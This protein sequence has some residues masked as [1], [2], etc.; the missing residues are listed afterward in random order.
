MSEH[1]NFLNWVKA[2]LKYHYMSNCRSKDAFAYI[3]VRRMSLFTKDMSVF[4]V[5]M[6]DPVSMW[7]HVELK[8]KSIRCL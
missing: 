6:I 3:L 8:I 2:V 1:S 5:R 4:S 7:D